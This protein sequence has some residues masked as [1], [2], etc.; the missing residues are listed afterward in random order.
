M[1]A[2]NDH[3]AEIRENRRGNNKKPPHHTM[4]RY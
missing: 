4:L 3:E 1:D 2:T